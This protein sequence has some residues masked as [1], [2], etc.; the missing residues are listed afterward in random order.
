MDFFVDVEEFEK[1]KESVREFKKWLLG[2]ECDIWNVE[3][4]KVKVSW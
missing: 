1:V 4:V 3:E 2:F